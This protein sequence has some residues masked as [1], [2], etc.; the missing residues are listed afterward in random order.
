MNTK[1][2]CLA[3]LEA[4]HKKIIEHKWDRQVDEPE[5]LLDNSYVTSAL[6]DF[7]I[8]APQEMDDDICIRLPEGWLPGEDPEASEDYA[9]VC[10]K[11]AEV[12]NLL[13]YEMSKEDEYL[14]WEAAQD[15]KDMH[16]EYYR[17]VGWPF[18]N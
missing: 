3:F 18:K 13:R 16:A 10:E 2:E 5:E 17:L 7:D 11:F 1:E 15:E 9:H 8:P 12:Y 6:K 4:A 14:M